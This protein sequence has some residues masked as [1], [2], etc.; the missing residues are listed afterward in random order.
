MSEKIEMMTSSST[1]NENTQ[2]IKGKKIYYF[3]KRLIDIMLSLF[4]LIMLSPIF[5]I[6]SLL[7][8]YGDNK[9][10][11][12]F[13]QKRIGQY[14]K[15]FYI[16]KFRSMVVD[17]EV[18]LKSN[19][20][21]YKKYLKNNYKLEPKEDPRI[22]KMGEF[23]R[24][25]S[26]DELPQLLNVLK[27]EMSLIGPRPVLKDELKEYSERIEH[28]LSVKPGVTGYWQVCGRSDVGYPERAYLEFYYVDKQGL[29]MDTEILFKTILL[30]LNRK[31]AY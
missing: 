27:G 17:A 22:T 9:G 21:L 7:Y 11:I 14:G 10:P 20:E 26:L 18:I 29:K 6:I 8:Q 19:R 4:G 13:K 25:T 24:K 16:Y 5:L 15:E 3:F 31:G 30:V 28:F 23:L 1:D 2:I 12:L